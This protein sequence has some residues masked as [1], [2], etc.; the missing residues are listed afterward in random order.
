MQETDQTD[1]SE[2]RMIRFVAH[3]LLLRIR[4]GQCP[5][6]HTAK[7][8]ANFICKNLALAEVYFKCLYRWEF[9]SKWGLEREVIKGF[10][11]RVDE[12]WKSFCFGASRGGAESLPTYF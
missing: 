6:C 12:A 7:L 2:R 3:P 1:Q 5:I 10:V 9:K 8:L 4:D 11:N